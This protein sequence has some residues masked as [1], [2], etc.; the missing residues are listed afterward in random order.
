M[1][2]M[3]LVA[4]AAGAVGVWAGFNSWQ[5]GPVTT[6]IQSGLAVLVGGNLL[7]CSWVWARAKPG[8][9]DAMV[10]PTLLLL[11]AAILIG[12]LPRLLWPLN[13]GRHMVGSIASAV[14]VIVIAVV[15][16]R[17]RRRLRDQATPV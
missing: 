13:D 11:S 1:K 16:I 14:I 5:L 3:L 17:K 15:Q 6:T 7:M 2:L 4:A 9:G 8:S 10:M 12:I